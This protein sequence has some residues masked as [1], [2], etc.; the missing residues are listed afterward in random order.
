NFATPQLV[1]RDGPIW[2]KD[3]QA[4]ATN[5]LPFCDS[6][7]ADLDAYAT[8][9]FGGGLRALLRSERAT[10]EKL[11]IFGFWRCNLGFRGLAQVGATQDGGD[12]RH[13]ADYVADRRAHGCSQVRLNVDPTCTPHR[14]C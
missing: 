10:E 5:P 13:S 12:Y 9:R 8:Y 4:Q 7:A 1:Y 2:C 11:G 3:L 14:V 6:P